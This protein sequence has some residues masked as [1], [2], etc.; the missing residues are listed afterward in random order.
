MKNSLQ[1]ELKLRMIDTLK[2]ETVKLR[3]NDV[4]PNFTR[5]KCNFDVPTTPATRQNNR[6]EQKTVKRGKASQYADTEGAD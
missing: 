6:P 3:E 2:V 1:L 4:T 5:S